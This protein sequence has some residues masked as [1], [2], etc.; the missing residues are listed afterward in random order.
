MGPLFAFFFVNM[1]GEWLMEHVPFLSIFGTP[2]FL[3]TA[4]FMVCVAC[5]LTIS[6]IMFKTLPIMPLLSGVLVL[7]FGALTLV[8]QNDTFIKLKPT[9]I[10]IMLGGALLVG[11]AFGR[12]FLKDILSAELSL[13][14]KGWH[15]LSLR[16]GLFFL[17]L[18]GLNEVV[19]RSMSTD[20]WVAF[21]VWGVLPITLV[22]ALS[23][24]TTLKT[25]LIEDNDTATA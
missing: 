14:D 9:I 1:R 4:V 16:W 3:A 17:F 13:T 6:K 12:P 21:K 25:H 22:F 24:Y 18:A 19:W 7:T 11:L 23:Q 2:I 20:A 8:L 15:I 10:N 5:S